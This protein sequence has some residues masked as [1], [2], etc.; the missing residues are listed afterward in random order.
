M[1]AGNRGFNI[2]TSRQ[3]RKVEAFITDYLPDD[4]SFGIIER[5][6]YYRIL[7]NELGVSSV[8]TEFR[9]KDLFDRDGNINPEVA[10]R[11]S[12][13][14]KAMKEAGL[15][16]PTIV[17]FTP[18]KWMYETAGKSPEKFV[19]LYE[20]CAEKVNS[21]C[22]ETGVAPRRVQVMNEVNTGF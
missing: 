1:E 21:I 3:T 9:L 19:G 15:E 16:S 4:K 11:Y 5:V 18:A 12:D 17:L 20:K 22:L 10:S 6:F 13:S 7:K 14:L 8:R 2:E